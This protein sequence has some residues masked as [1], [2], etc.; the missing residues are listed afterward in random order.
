[1]KQNIK[2]IFQSFSFSLW[3]SFFVFI[4]IV[5]ESGFDLPLWFTKTIKV[6]SIITLFIG[7]IIIISRYLRGNKIPSFKVFDIDA[8]FVLFLLTMSVI[9]SE[10][11][12]FYPLEFLE[13]DVWLKIAIIFLFFR[14]LFTLK[15]NFKYTKINPA[16][17]FVF[18]FF[19]IIILGSLLLLLP[20]ATN[21]KI[22]Y[23]D[24]LFTST[25]AVCVTGLAVVDTATFYTPFGQG[26][27]LLLIQIGGLGIMTF[28]S[29]FSYFFMGSAS[30]G[31][32]MILS[33]LTN[34]EKLGEVF[35]TLKNIII[36]TF[37]FEFLGAVLI[38]Y[39]IDNEIINDFGDKVFFSV[40]HSVSAFCNAG[41][42][43]LSNSLYENVFR[44]NYFLHIIV[45]FLIILGG[46]G[47]PIIFNL[48]RFL[49][50]KISNLFKII[51]FKK[52]DTHLPWVLNL[53]SKLI[54]STTF[55]LILFGMILILIFEYNNTLSEHSFFGKIVTSFFGSVTTRTAGFNTVDMSALTLPT[56]L[57]IIVLMWIGASPAST[58]GGIKTS[59]F[60]LA[61]LNIVS[62]AKSKNRIEIFGREISQI[63]INKAFTIIFLS[64][65]V[66]SFSVFGL[67]LTDS[68]KNFVDI[69]FECVSAFATVGLSRGITAQLSNTG[70]IIIIFTMFIGRVSM[71]SILIAFIK[72]IKHKKYR[73]PT[74]EILIN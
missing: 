32:Q 51:F 31:N 23:I 46:L 40:F 28:V 15:F 47:F 9:R 11:I 10:G 53:N 8:L 30:Y 2:H 56:T 21:E 67:V 25:S 37:T 59:T 61:F 69:F 7:V 55:I 4:L 71:F 43:L 65:L 68:D 41:F 38:Y 62:L 24:A 17:L 6:L 14:E 26:I 66:I 52:R 20:S 29:Y 22:S 54:L 42:S 18:S 3:L 45:A 73:F 35:N 33:E 49:K 50:N 60:A 34:N 44:F 57:I 12:E 13:K 39:S 74:E 48:W 72:K 36:V 70:K 27:I 1:M 64:L 16:Q 63:S 5:I 58:G 19:V